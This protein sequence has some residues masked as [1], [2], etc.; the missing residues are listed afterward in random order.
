MADPSKSEEGGLTFA[1]KRVYYIHKGIVAELRSKNQILS[2]EC[3][4]LKDRLKNL[5][6]SDF[7]P[8]QSCAELQKQMDALTKKKN[9]GKAC[10]E[11]QVKLVSQSNKRERPL[12]L[13][14]SFEKQG[15]SPEPKRKK[16]VLDKLE[17]RTVDTNGD[18]QVSDCR[19]EVFPPLSPSANEDSTESS[20]V[21]VLAPETELATAE[22]LTPKKSKSLKIAKHKSNIPLHDRQCGG[23]DSDV[24]EMSSP[25]ILAVPET[26]DDNVFTD[27]DTDSQKK[28]SAPKEESVAGLDKSKNNRLK[29]D[30]L[31]Q[32]FKK[33][34]DVEHL[35][36]S[37]FINITTQDP[38]QQMDKSITETFRALSAS[39]ASSLANF[40]KKGER[41]DS[42]SKVVIS[43]DQKD[44][45]QSNFG[46]PKSKTVKKNSHDQEKNTSLASMSSNLDPNGSV[47]PGLD[48]SYYMDGGKAR[49]FLSGESQSNLDETLAPNLLTE[50][51]LGTQ[52][53]RLTRLGL[54]H[55]HKLNAAQKLSQSDKRSQP[56]VI[57]L[58]GIPLEAGSSSEQNKTKR[59]DDE[60]N[61]LHSKVEDVTGI[62]SVHVTKS[63]SAM[64]K[65]SDEANH[66]D[67]SD[68]GAVFSDKDS[69]DEAFASSPQNT[70]AEHEPQQR[71]SYT[72]KR[73]GS[74]HKKCFGLGGSHL[75]EGFGSGRQQKETKTTGRSTEDVICVNNEHEDDTGISSSDEEK[76]ERLRGGDSARRAT[77]LEAQHVVKDE[78][79]MSN[80][81]ENFESTEEEIVDQLPDRPELED[82]FDRVPSSAKRDIAHVEVVR[83][84]SERDKLDGFSCK[85]CHEFYKNSGLS[86]EELKKKLKACS[87][88]KERYQPPSTPEHFWTLGIPDTAEMLDRQRPRTP[89]RESPVA[90]DKRPRRR[91]QLQ[92][93]F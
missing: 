1:L 78:D 69:D 32:A 41:N 56:T 88:H 13:E 54:R 12:S 23:D 22:D 51:Q 9:S 65:V 50:E 55:K 35:G 42:V 20:S 11:N 46:F 17:S 83:K 66:C 30:T 6:S 25:R 74:V 21:R 71:V 81:N 24:S 28:G 80:D 67:F 70:L 82:S 45:S 2:E 29:Q 79:L 31:N 93:K 77:G 86:E 62:Q 36:A 61:S 49:V 14:A 57:D 75:K 58:T 59:K 76:E 33:P 89:S 26:M 87:R 34:R 84:K 63:S 3:K 91:R 19:P 8:C 27:R 44:P 85:Q 40:E 92:Q 39:S 38:Q 53:S 7:R 90:A 5:P 47:D 18:I 48:Y 15:T 16:I 10:E 43:T 64:P 52:R 72:S 60:K 37:S 4:R 68:N 73:S